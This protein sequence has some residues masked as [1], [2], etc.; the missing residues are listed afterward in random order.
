MPL[1]RRELALGAAACLLP[2]A[3]AVRAQAYPAKP[4]R[5]VVP[6]PPG[7]ATDILA[8]LVA[9]QL[10]KSMNATFIVE[11][12][13]GAGGL[14]GTDSVAKA[15]PDGYTLVMATIATLGIAPSLYPK[16]PYQA[17]DFAPLSNLA[18]TPQVL[19]TSPSQ[20]FKTLKEFVA[21]AKTQEVSY[22]SSGNGAASHLS[23]E[24][25]R[26]AAGIRAVHVPFKGN[27]DA[28][29]QVMGGQLPVMFDAVPGILQHVKS[30]K[31]R[32]LGIA[33][34]QRSPYLPDVPTIA[35]QGY[36]GFEAVGWIGIAAPAKTPAPILD[37]LN[38]ELRQMMDKPEVR[39][40][41]TA[42]A[43]A[44]VGDSRE[45]FA[46]FIAAEQA[47]WQRVVI[48]SGAKAE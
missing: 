33:A 39:A 15:A 48:A 27:A 17:S 1:T 29:M 11:N 31:L 20:P 42:G 36:P 32:A 4:I 7:Q 19:V 38:A 25:F 43:F 30:G 34:A 47:K 14:L 26:G 2:A 5:I 13:A 44:A 41:F 8:R 9:D 28:Q 37:R 45:Q 23:M 3:T 35:E 40:Q 6:F 10:G 16:I 21:Y 22:G 46:A 24:M 18:L 12:K